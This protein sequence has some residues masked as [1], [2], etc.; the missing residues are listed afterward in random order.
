MLAA[1]ELPKD[2]WGEAAHAAAYLRN[3]T[4]QQG[5][6][7]PEELWTGKRQKLAHLRVFGCVA[8]A[9]FAQ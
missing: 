8:Y 4:P 9:Q 6:Q 7:C 3:S 1:A 2:L 5:E